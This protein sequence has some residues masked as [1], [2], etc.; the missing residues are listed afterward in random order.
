MSID[1]INSNANDPLREIY[2]PVQK[3]K[4]KAK[5]F[6]TVKFKAIRRINNVK[7]HALTKIGLSSNCDCLYISDEVACNHLSWINQICFQ[8]EKK[9]KRMY[10]FG[11]HQITDCNS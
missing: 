8:P 11:S 9:K 6:T 1:A 10:T 7:A 3:I 4:E 2:A 5:D